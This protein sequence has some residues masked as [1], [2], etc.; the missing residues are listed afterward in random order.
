M[1]KDFNELL[2]NFGTKVERIRQLLI[3]VKKL[4]IGSPMRAEIAMDIAVIL[5]AI[6][7]YGSGTESLVKRCR[8]DEKI[9]FPFYNSLDM[10][11]ILPS[12]QLV[13]V[14][15]SNQNATFQVRDDLTCEKKIPKVYLS[16]QTWMNEVV[17]NFKNREYDPLSRLKV[18]KLIADKE[19]AHVDSNIDESVEYIRNNNVFPLTIIIGNEQCTYNGMNLL[20]ETIIGI[21]TEF[22]FAYEHYIINHSDRIGVDQDYYYKIQY[23]DAKSFLHAT[24]AQ[25]RLQGYL[26]TYDYDVP[27]EQIVVGQYYMKY[28]DGGK[29]KISII[30]K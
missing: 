8:L 6:L 26:Q 3:D 23:K 9:I 7:C 21:A 18:V 12:Y 24:Q 15:S 5:R 16:F 2:V 29:Y 14:A 4:E 13:M 22:V 19:G 1:K 27:C 28:K 17:I 11:N 20:Y 30:D 25:P 10:Y